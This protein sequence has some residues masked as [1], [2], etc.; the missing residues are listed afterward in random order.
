MIK[1]NK[2]IVKNRIKLLRKEKGLTQTQLAEMCGLTK[3]TVS[4]Y[5]NQNFQPGIES[6][7]SIASVLNCN[8]NELFDVVLLVSH[9]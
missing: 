2:A 5:E 9:N 4:M 7:Y 8:I 3:N 1:V 6:A